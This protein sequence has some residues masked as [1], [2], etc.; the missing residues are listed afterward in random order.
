MAILKQTSEGTPGKWELFIPE[1]DGDQVNRLARIVGLHSGEQEAD[2]FAKTRTLQLIRTLRGAFGP[3]LEENPA[4]HQ[5]LMRGLAALDMLRWNTGTEGSFAPYTDSRMTPDLLRRITTD[6]LNLPENSRHG[7]AEWTRVLAIAAHASRRDPRSS[8]H[9]FARILPISNPLLIPGNPSYNSSTDQLEFETGKISLRNLPGWLRAHTR[10]TPGDPVVLPVDWAGSQ[11]DRGQTLAERIARY[12]DA[13]VIA[14]TGPV[15]ADG[16]SRLPSSPGTWIEVLPGRPEARTWHAELDETLSARS[17][18]VSL[19]SF[20]TAG[21]DHGSW[22]APATLTP[23]IQ[24]AIP[25]E[26]PVGRTPTPPDSHTKVQAK[27]VPRPDLSLPI[28]AVGVP[29]EELPYMPELV[30]QLRS[31]VSESK[32]HVAETDWNGLPQLLLNNY[33]HLLPEGKADNG[34]LMLSLGKSVE[35]LITLDPQDPHE[36]VNQGVSPGETQP[37]LSPIAEEP[38]ENESTQ[39]STTNE[40]KTLVPSR[41]KSLDRF[42][43]PETVNGTFLTGAHSQS[44]SGI[45]AATRGS[46]SIGFG[47]GLGVGPLNA[48]KT[49]IGVSGT[50]NSS[51]R[52]M[53]H[54]GD[55]E[56][57]HVEDNRV[58]S[59]LIAYQPHWT[60][61]IRTHKSQRWDHILGTKIKTRADGPRLKLWIPKH[62]LTPPPEH[63]VRDGIGDNSQKMPRIFFASGVTNLPTLFD[64]I[65]AS[66]RSAGIR[67]PIGGATRNELI[68]SLWS[69]DLRLDDAVN[70]RDGLEVTLHSDSGAQIAAFRLHAER[71][72]K[73][74]NLGAPSDGSHIENIRTA[75]HGSGGGHAI[76]NSSSISF[77]FM[78]LE[79]LAGLL[80]LNLQA[81]LA[82]QN[83]FATSANRIGLS[84]WVERLI[85]RTLAFWQDFTIRV[86]IF[87]PGKAQINMREMTVSAIIRT[88]VEDALTF[89]F[90]APKEDLE[91]FIKLASEVVS[92][93]LPAAPHTDSLEVPRYIA[94]GRGVGLGNPEIFQETADSLRSLIAGRLRQFGF[95]PGEGSTPFGERRMWTHAPDQESKQRNQALLTKFISPASL[96]SNFDQLL[97]DGLRV[98]FHR[99]RGG[100][101][102]TWDVDAAAVTIRATLSELPGH[103]QRIPDRHLVMLTMGLGIAGMASSGSRTISVGAKLNSA[104]HQLKN[105]GLGVDLSRTVGARENVTFISNLPQLLEFHGDGIKFPL[106]VDYQV[107]FNLEHTG[108]QG[109]IFRGVRNGTPLDLRAQ[110]GTALL[111]KTSHA[112]ATPAI[113]TLPA[114]PSILDGAVVSFLDSTGVHSAAEKLFGNHFVGPQGKADQFISSFTSNVSLRSFLQEIVDKHYSTDL[115]F[116]AGW[117]QSDFGGISIEATLGHVTYEGKVEGDFVKANIALAQSEIATTRQLARGVRTSFDVVSVGGPVPTQNPHSPNSLSTSAG[118]SH[119]R[120]K[121]TAV[122]HMNAAAIERLGL[123]FGQ[124]YIFSMDISFFIRVLTERHGKFTFS[125]QEAKSIRVEGRKVMFILTERRV[126]ELYANGTINLPDEPILDVL[127]RWKDGKVRHSASLIAS[128]LNWRSRSSMPEELAER[129]RETAGIISTQ[130]RNGR[131]PVLDKNARLEFN[132]V[133]NETLEDTENS[134]HDSRIPVFMTGPHPLLSAVGVAPFQFDDPAV[135]TLDITQRLI[136]AIAPDLVADPS[137]WSDPENSK[138][139]KIGRLQGAIDFVQTTLSHG[140]DVAM[141]DDI[142]SP[143]GKT[144]SLANTIGWLLE[145]NI[146]VNIRGTLDDD[147]KVVDFAPDEG[148][149]SY[150]YKTQLQSQST[151]TSDTIDASASLN[152]GYH[153]GSTKE[154]VQGTTGRGVEIGQVSQKA[155]HIDSYYDYNGRYQAKAGFT[156]TVTVTR[157]NMAGR[158]I[159]NK[160]VNWYHHSMK[161]AIRNF[162]PANPG[163]TNPEHSYSVTDSARG[164]LKVTIPRSLVEIEPAPEQ[165]LPQTATPLPKLPEDSYIVGA[166]LNGAQSAGIQLLENLFGPA[167][168]GHKTQTSILIREVL[169]R[170]HTATQLRHLWD[171]GR[172]TLSDGI[173]IPGKPNVRARLVMVG[174]ISHARVVGSLH[175]AGPGHYTKFE[176]GTTLTFTTTPPR[177]QVSVETSGSG[178]LVN[179]N[180]MSGTTPASRGVS[181][182]ISDAYATNQR[183]EQH[184]KEQGL[185]YL[186]EGRVTTYIEATETSY[187]LLG[188]ATE[189]RTLSS[190]PVEGTVYFVVPADKMHEMREYLNN[191]EISVDHLPSGVQRVEKESVSRHIAA[192]LLTSSGIIPEV[193][194][195]HIAPA[196]R[197]WSEPS[198]AA[199]SSLERTL[200]DAGDGAWS[201]VLPERSSTGGPGTPLH[202][203]NV[204]GSIRWMDSQTGRDLSPPTAGAGHISSLDFSPTGFTISPDGEAP[205]PLGPH[206]DYAAALRPSVYRTSPGSA[207]ETGSNAESASTSRRQEK[208]ESPGQAQDGETTA[209]HV[210]AGSA[211]HNIA[212]SPPSASGSNADAVYD[213]LVPAGAQPQSIVGPS[214]MATSS[215]S[216]EGI[217]SDMPDGE[218]VDTTNA[219]P[220][221]GP[222]VTNQ[223]RGTSESVGAQLRKPPAPEPAVV[224]EGPSTI[225]A[226]SE[227]TG[228]TAIDA[229][230]IEGEAPTAQ[231][232]LVFNALVT[233]VADR[234][235][236]RIDLKDRDDSA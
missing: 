71:T 85:S 229:R 207:V 235:S 182:S 5:D 197:P 56:R 141:I 124:A 75:I 94:D 167:A 194:V 181:D 214:P 134:I 233:D 78:R 58:E 77:P 119:S 10:W 215:H 191:K 195:P 28:R 160:L 211:P 42:R 206:S 173:F 216:P 22:T 2:A 170:T 86:E 129:F 24:I 38:Q 19:G 164:T 102:L 67:L 220:G 44:Y 40:P 23:S 183:S 174:H 113:S 132:R 65:V 105:S 62:Y 111:M 189:G 165:T 9:D 20:E 159:N 213:T 57:G 137:T 203:V 118:I 46:A 36:I 150:R 12:L 156:L 98:T 53:A 97:Q 208:A 87:V 4:N 153:G 202:A 93:E 74:W 114:S 104:Y 64:N 116:D 143:E 140:R 127:S 175:G 186:L 48:F 51:S 198:P 236:Q 161:G 201:V 210:D 18:A 16:T 11:R 121:T 193:A 168:A 138:S 230:P 149:E 95:L 99:A 31:L 14:H 79:F 21:H 6:V 35:V 30:A 96:V 223:F 125:A 92:I 81:A 157:V 32:K 224:S 180:T 147:F 146:I 226:Q 232:D 41:K 70:A 63:G 3:Q 152:A 91:N 221:P 209:R 172:T 15:H 212:T 163:A 1:P 139:R 117:F 101:R 7:P 169:G 89:G 109:R 103:A 120:Q 225:G 83:A 166:A 107:E 108:L 144:F 60:V 84:V 135:S 176:K 148:G 158:P 54:I 200:L 55:A 37:F 34:G 171:T 142:M 88:S 80:G 26:Q 33:R 100:A 199:V 219:D 228:R 222:V 29:R 131:I 126:L 61:R 66:L 192:N 8:L 204:D 47:V 154:T 136:N 155:T 52:S 162:D 196:L 82:F 73:A 69:L 110:P 177:G 231:A 130:H 128:V 179:D 27:E 205:L 43:S 25:P 133:F 184:A 227:T 49:G 59:K 234:S 17:L 185:S 217:A 72:K 190:K 187:G 115:P 13:P 188:H 50:A 145:E 76:S 68:Q 90:P 122:T 178:G 112:P 106:A 123:D 39:P 151:S 45:T 218:A